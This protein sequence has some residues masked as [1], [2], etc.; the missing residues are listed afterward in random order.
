MESSF[1]AHMCGICRDQQERLLAAGN[2]C[3]VPCR[4]LVEDD[5]E[6]KLT[7]AK[8]KEYCSKFK[9]KKRIAPYS[10]SRPKTV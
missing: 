3:Q 5:N 10:S 4:C 7:N 8:I 1:F 6:I 2:G 9:K